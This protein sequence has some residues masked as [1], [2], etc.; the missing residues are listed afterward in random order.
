MFDFLKRKPK[1]EYEIETELPEV[2]IP[3]DML[4]PRH[5]PLTKEDVDNAI[6]HIESQ[7]VKI[8]AGV[9]FCLAKDKSQVLIVPTS[10]VSQKDIERFQQQVTQLPGVGGTSHGRD[11]C[12]GTYVKKE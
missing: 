5:R 10:K 7:N 9:C 12:S 8:P 3:D 1:K 11:F 4:I 2:K 6:A